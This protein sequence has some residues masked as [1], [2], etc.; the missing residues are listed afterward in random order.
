MGM[1]IKPLAVIIFFLISLLFLPGDAYSKGGGR[2]GGGIGRG[3]SRGGKFSGYLGSGH[4][5][6]SHV[7]P[8]H[9]PPSGSYYPGRSGGF[10]WGG[11]L[12][13]GFSFYAPSGCYSCHP[14]LSW[15]DG[16]RSCTYT[17]ISSA[18]IAEDRML[19]ERDIQV[20]QTWR[21]RDPYI[22]P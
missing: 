13:A 4:I 7:Y 16:F 21:D 2:G 18:E 6:R 10:Y 5:S 15:Y 11:Y 1:K 22:G 8:G 3:F 17:N 9:I 14:G 12:G 19:T 20:W